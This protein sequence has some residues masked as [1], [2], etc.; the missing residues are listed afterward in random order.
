MTGPKTDDRWIKGD[1][2]FEQIRE[3]KENQ[4]KNEILALENQDIYFRKKNSSEYR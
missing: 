4:R 1:E 3:F 2:F